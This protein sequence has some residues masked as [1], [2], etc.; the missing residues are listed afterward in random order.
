MKPVALHYTA[1][2]EPEEA[3]GYHAFCPML[4]GCHSCGDTIEE[5]IANIKEA[6]ELYVESLQREG[7]A[8]PLEDILIKTVDVAL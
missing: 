7:E 6:I 3:G 2:L 5:A 4:K 1:I 8:V